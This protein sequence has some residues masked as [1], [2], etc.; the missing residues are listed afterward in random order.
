ML[1]SYFILFFYFIIMFLIIKEFKESIIAQT[2]MD[3]L[4]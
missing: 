4:L 3:V 2:V 1:Q